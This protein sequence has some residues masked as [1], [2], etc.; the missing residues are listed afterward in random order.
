MNQV[1]L[2]GKVIT[3]PSA[4]STRDGTQN[5]R[6]MLEVEHKT[7]SGEIKSEQYQIRAWRNTALWMASNLQNGDEIMIQGYMN[8]Q[9]SNRTFGQLIEVTATTV[10]RL[11][12]AKRAENVIS[13]K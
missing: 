5:L 4:G 1:I 13:E 8:Y 7:A 2:T 10:M 12:P 9:P 11:A 3:T 6:M